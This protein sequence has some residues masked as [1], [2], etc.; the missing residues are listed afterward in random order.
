ML[1]KLKPML[2]KQQPMQRKLL[3]KLQVQAG[4]QADGYETM[5]NHKGLVVVQLSHSLSDP[6]GG[7]MG[8]R[9]IQRGRLAV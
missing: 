9:A 1:Q 8:R 5:P 4:G 3:Q 7:Q 6:V 2:Q